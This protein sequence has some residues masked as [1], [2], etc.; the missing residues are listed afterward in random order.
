MM[1][2][3]VV[4]E[5]NTSTTASNPT[6]SE[7]YKEVVSGLKKLGITDKDIN[8][9][10][11]LGYELSGA[12]PVWDAA[13]SMTGMSII[14]VSL[15]D[16]NK[17]GDIFDIMATQSADLQNRISFEV[18]DE[19]KVLGELEKSA[20]EDARAKAGRIAQGMGLTLGDITSIEEIETECEPAYDWI[21]TTSTTAA[22]SLPERGSFDDDYNHS[23]IM[24]YEVEYRV[25]FETISN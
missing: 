8:M 11:M 16:G 22:A 25:T 12:R 6:P 21:R 4:R 24:N 14:E 3:L 13:G 10:R 19:A 1:V 15:D 7:N 18:T 2:T 5:Y 20:I 23:K 17:L 9:T